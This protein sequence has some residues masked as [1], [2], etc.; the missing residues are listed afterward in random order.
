MDPVTKQPPEVVVGS[1]AEMRTVARDLRAA[2][3][4]SRAQLAHRAG[5]SGVDVD[6][7]ENNG[8]SA[9]ALLDVAGALGYEIVL[10]PAAGQSPPP[11]GVRGRSRAERERDGRLSERLPL[12]LPIPLYE[13]LKRHA[14]SHGRS[15]AQI[16]RDAMIQWMDLADPTHESYFWP[17]THE[18][19]TP[20]VSYGGLR[21]TE[22]LAAQAYRHAAFA[23]VA[24]GEVV[25]LA[26]RNMLLK[27]GQAL[28][29]IGCHIESD[30]PTALILLQRREV[31][32][33]DRDI[34]LRDAADPSTSPERL[35]VMATSTNAAVLVAVVTNPSTP[36]PA[37]VNVAFQAA[38]RWCRNSRYATE[39]PTA[40]MRTM[41]RWEGT[42]AGALDY[43]S[44]CYHLHQDLVFHPNASPH[45]LDSLR[46]V[47]D[48]IWE[49]EVSVIAHERLEEM[50][51]DWQHLVRTEHGFW[52]K[53]KA[54]W[55]N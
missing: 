8:G 35:S 42:P 13:A 45:L 17:G 29:E 32:A 54:V 4:L 30:A 48:D 23:G 53:L 36:K 5:V 52:A 31:L 6:R 15:T 21:L 41:A 34:L 28:H 55:G 26:A 1:Q 24:A 44:C 27:D 43:L 9:A 20:T 18:R 3:G 49:G 16:M 11:T 12:K 39:A 2:Q 19:G 25:R 7:L 22:E 10:R 37:V 47:A 46:H 38:C 14:T 50:D 33:A 40:L 51:I